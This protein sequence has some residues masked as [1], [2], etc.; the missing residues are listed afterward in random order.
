MSA[1]ILQREDYTLTTVFPSSGSISFKQDF[2][3]IDSLHS[4]LRVRGDQRLAHDPVMDR[5]RYER[6]ANDEERWAVRQGVIVDTK[7]HLYERAHTSQSDV[8]YYQ[9]SEGR[10]YHPKFP[11][12]SFDVVLKRG[13]EYSKSRGFVD[14]ER[15]V[16]E[17]EGW[18]EIMMVLFDPKTVIDS[19]AIVISE[20][21]KKKGTAFTDN[22]VD[23]FTKTLDSVTGE[24]IVVMRR[25]ASG[26]NDDEYRAAAICFDQNYFSSERAGEEMDIY[27]KE[28]PVFI[29]PR[30]DPRGDN[31]LFD[32]EF[33]KQKGA[34][35]EEKT[36]GYLDEC[37]LFILHYADTI[38][39]KF[40]EPKNVKEAF[41]AVINKF[42]S[43]RKG[44]VETV[45]NAARGV[46]EFGS[47]VVNK[48]S[49]L[50]NKTA[51]FFEELDRYGRMKI[52][53]I[54]VGCGLSGEFSIEGSGTFSIGSVIKSIGGF[55]SGVISAIPGL[56]KDKDYCI[57]CGACGALIKR[58][59]RRGGKCPVCPAIRKC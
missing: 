40:F 32:A 25:F 51:Q 50:V 8:T 4:Q 54:M 21:G 49:S 7:K 57:N 19:K 31:E 9:D 45:S 53:E 35:E 29:D 27:F 36:K 58:V 30:V 23:I 2:E 52:E 33:K 42:D 11:G 3:S 6:A 14:Y 10:I 48:V 22:F 28:H 34:I 13:L 38:C 1:E 44:L 39:A 17:F 59:V 26:T 15:E 24:I 37:K 41:C 47:N 5:A 20:A 16:K 56:F 55:I 43:L 18:K 46:L 12:E